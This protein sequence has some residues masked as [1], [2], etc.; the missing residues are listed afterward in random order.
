MKAA[1]QRIGLHRVAAILVGCALALEIVRTQVV[2]A[3]SVAGI[4]CTFGEVLFLALA[5]GV[6]VAARRSHG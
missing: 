1:A 4:A 5:A 6:F 2:S 3:G